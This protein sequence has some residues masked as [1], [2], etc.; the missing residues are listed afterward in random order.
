MLITLLRS[1]AFALIMNAALWVLLVACLVNLGN[2]PPQFVEASA[3]STRVEMPVPIARITNLFT[4][5]L[6]LALRPITNLDNPFATRHFIPPVVP[7]PPPP[8]TRQAQ[9]TYHGFYQAGAGPIQ[10]FLTV[11]QKTFNG[12]VGAF[13]A[14]PWAIAEIVSAAVTLTNAAPGTNAPAPP[15]RI[16]LNKTVP[17]EVPVP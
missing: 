17:L 5:S 10:A 15:Q 3:P 8:T 13:A 12:P 11:D 2:V 16:P 1:R 14:K 9:V 4:G 7:P 6:G